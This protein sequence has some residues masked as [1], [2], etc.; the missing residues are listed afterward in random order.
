MKCRE[1]AILNPHNV[2]EAFDIYL[3]NG[4]EGLEVIEYPPIVDPNEEYRL[5][6]VALENPEDGAI[7][8]QLQFLMF[9]K[10]KA[11]AFFSCAVD[12]V[13]AFLPI[14]KLDTYSTIDA[15]TDYYLLSELLNAIM[16]FEYFMLKFAAPGEVKKPFFKVRLVSAIICFITS[17]ILQYGN[18]DV[19]EKEIYT[20]QFTFQCWAYFSLVRFCGVHHMLKFSGRWQ[21]LLRVFK[22]VIPLLKDLLTIYLIVLLVF[23]QIGLFLFGGRINSKINGIY[24]E[25]TG[26]DVGGNYDLI[27]FNDTLNSMYY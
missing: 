4:V 22:M 9:Y 14:V 3:E 24:H 13:I 19:T 15:R 12:L 26:N 20:Y 1:A 18:Y 10:S 2:K 5:L 17:N 23:C 8:E 25:K 6:K 7:D 11:F 16:F 21:T 27:N